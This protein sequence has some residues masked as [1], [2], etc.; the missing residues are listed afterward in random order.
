MML[1]IHSTLDSDM[2]F[3]TMKMLL[4]IILGIST[5]IKKEETKKK[6]YWITRTMAVIPMVSIFI[7]LNPQ[8]YNKNIAINSIEKEKIGLYVNSEEYRNLNKELITAYEEIIEYERGNSER[9]KYEFEKIQAYISSGQNDLEEVLQQYY[10]KIINYENKSK[11]DIA[12]ITEKSNYIN[13]LINIL[14]KENNPQLYKWIKIFT[15]IN[16]DEY[17]KTKEKL[18]NVACSEYRTIEEDI[19]YQKLTAN[20]KSSIEKYNKYFFEI[21]IENTTDIDIK[22]YIDENCKIQIGNKE[23][24]IIYHTHTTEGYY[25]QKEHEETEDGKTKDSKYNVLR[26]GEKLREKL[27]EKEFK[28]RHLQEYH[29]LEGINEA[30][31]KSRQTLENETKNETIEIVFDI[32]RDA[33]ME[34]QKVNTVKIEDNEVAQL[35]FVIAIG[36]ENWEENLKWAIN[37]QKKA[38]EMYPGLFKPLLIYNNRYNQDITKYATLLEVGNNA[39]TI[40]EAEKSMLYFSNIIEHVINGE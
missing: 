37:L 25:T 13:E 5:R 11:Y 27:E 39:N 2:C 32:H 23:E 30:Y 6:H 4:F 29:D 17:E 26:V 16:I 7:Y 19:S 18:E 36:H 8:I 40:E 28:V 10:E 12:Q 33:Y 34:E 21:D 9:N 24:I 31:T 35:R 3:P 38:N 20:Y 1:L 22:Q 15:K 14:E